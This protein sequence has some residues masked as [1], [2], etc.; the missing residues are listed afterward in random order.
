MSDKIINEVADSMAVED[1]ESTSFPIFPG[2][3]PAELP[4]HERG[5]PQVGRPSSIFRDVGCD[6]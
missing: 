6:H 5:L 3:P 4:E 2:W 1:D